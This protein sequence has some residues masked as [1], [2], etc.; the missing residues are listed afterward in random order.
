ME[1]NF[2]VPVFSPGKK[3]SDCLCL[4]IYVKVVPK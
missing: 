3:N 2:K 4:L 1:F